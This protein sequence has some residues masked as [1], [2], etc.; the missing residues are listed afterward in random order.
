M[1]IFAFFWHHNITL[2]LTY[3]IEMDE[4]G[5]RVSSKKVFNIIFRSADENNNTGNT[6]DIIHKI[7]K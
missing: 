1:I 5:R 2:T 4:M 6:I 7:I 3:N